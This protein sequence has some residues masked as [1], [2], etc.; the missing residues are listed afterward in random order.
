VHLKVRFCGQIKS[1]PIFAAGKSF[2]SRMITTAAAEGL[3]VD[4][5]ASPAVQHKKSDRWFHPQSPILFLPR[6]YTF[7]ARCYALYAKCHETICNLTEL[8]K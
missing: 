6:S 8:I 2:G 1:K 5:Y 4:P 7:H 3:L